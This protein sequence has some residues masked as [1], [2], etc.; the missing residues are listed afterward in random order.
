LRE[1]LKA[2]KAPATGNGNIQV[3]GKYSHSRISNYLVTARASGSG[4]STQA[5]GVRVGDVGLT[6][7]LEVRPGR[8]AL[9][10]LVVSALGG[11]F[12]GE[13]TLDKSK[14]F[15]IAGETRTIS[16]PELA[17]ARGIDAGA[18]NGTVSGPVDL[19][20]VLSV[21]RARG[22]KATANLSVEGSAKER[23][24]AGVVNVSFDQRAGTLELRNS[25]LATAATRIQFDGALERSIRA[26]VESTD[27]GDIFLAASLAGIGR[28]EI[29]THRFERAGLP[30]SAA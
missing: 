11:T 10:K 19:E 14:R 7:D 23:P 27:L 26:T 16:I 2:V 8:A 24:V 9:Q 29:A 4:L 6:S 17:R 15:H 28:P 1:L 22:L 3:T 18:W 20:G 13:A 25:H 21:A 5:A 30:D 12:T